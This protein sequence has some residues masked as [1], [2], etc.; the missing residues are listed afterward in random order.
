M[1]KNDFLFAESLK[2][3]KLFNNNP[4]NYVQLGFS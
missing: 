3:F 2:D 4:Y 1:I